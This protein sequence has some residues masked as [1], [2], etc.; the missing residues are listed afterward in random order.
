MSARYEIRLIAPSGYPHIP[1]AMRRGIERLEAAGHR[2]AGREVLDRLDLR[3]AGTDAERAAD[4]NGL[5]DP[6]RPLPDVVLAIRGGY[7]AHPLL[8][9]L[10][11]DALGERLRDAPVAMIGHSDFTALQSA[12]YARAGIVTYG[13]PMLGADF[14]AP[15]LDPLTWEHVWRTL[16]DEEGLGEWEAPHTPDIAVDGTLWGGNLAMLAGLVG[17]PY[18]PSIEGGLL[19]IEDIAEPPFRV[20]RMLYHLLHAGV[21]GA[22]KA[23]LVGDFTGYRVAE[24]DNGYDL[25]T[26]FERI[27]GAAG[28]PIVRGL[29]FG[30]GPAKFT[31]PFGAAGRLVVAD[32]RATLRFSGHPRPKTP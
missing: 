16:A 4:L 14:G 21:L 29:P 13:G 22:Q 1:E 24:Y 7:G 25:D 31:L 23:L 18:F 19:Y 30:H 27:A 5:A 8:P 15:E 3:F 32:G 28:I 10:N 12:L 17:S 2:I 26:V 20:E 6:S 9:L 11:Y